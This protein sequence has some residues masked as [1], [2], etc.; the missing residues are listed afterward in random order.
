[1]LIPLSLVCPLCQCFLDPPYSPSW[2]LVHLKT[3]CEAGPRENRQVVWDIEKCPA[4]ESLREV[5]CPVGQMK[6]FVP[7]NGS[8]LAVMELACGPA[9]LVLYSWSHYPKVVLLICWLSVSRLLS[10]P[11]PPAP[12]GWAP[13]YSVRASLPHARHSLWGRQGIMILKLK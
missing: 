9:L 10:S 6:P 12:H 5:L 3:N 7:A 13:K 2:F 11:P 1:M 4:V 8:F